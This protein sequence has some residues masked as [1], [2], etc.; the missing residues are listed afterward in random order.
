MACRALTCAIG[1]VPLSPEPVASRQ[2][3]SLVPAMTALFLL[4]TL[5]VFRTHLSLWV[6]VAGPLKAPQEADPVPK[7]LS[8]NADD[9]HLCGSPSSGAY[10]VMKI[11]GLPVIDVGESEE[12]TVAVKADDLLEGDTAAAPHRPRLA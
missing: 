9:R 1:P 3:L 11:E 7:V 4:G 12:I 8:L 2:G 6:P 10:S 5:R